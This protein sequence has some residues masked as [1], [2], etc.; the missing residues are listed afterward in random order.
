[1]G[2]A[3]DA[4]CFDIP[5]TSRTSGFLC[6]GEAALDIAHNA[7]M[8]IVGLLGGKSKL[9]LTSVYDD[10]FAS[11]G[12][13]FLRAARVGNAALL[14]RLMEQGVDIFARDANG[15]L[16][17]HWAAKG[18]YREIVI[19]LLEAGVHADART[20]DGRSGARLWQWGGGFW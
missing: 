8:E 17:L 4:A 1:M 6:S 12:A 16:A 13:V 2:A 15:M 3:G 18:G 7:Y 11:P 14:R 19:T 9:G 5:T 20:H 10:P